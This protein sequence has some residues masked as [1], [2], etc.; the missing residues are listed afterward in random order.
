VKLTEQNEA[1]EKKPKEVNHKK[2]KAQK[3]IE[4]IP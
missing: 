3:T 4:F 1:F 2:Q